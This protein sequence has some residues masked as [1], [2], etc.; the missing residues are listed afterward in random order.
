MY[1]NAI[2]GFPRKPFPYRYKTDY[3]LDHSRKK[4]MQIKEQRIGVKDDRYF[5]R[6]RKLP[7]LSVFYT[8]LDVGRETLQKKLERKRK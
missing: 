3:R 5:R 7:F 6:D 1:N 8:I 2:P 4:I